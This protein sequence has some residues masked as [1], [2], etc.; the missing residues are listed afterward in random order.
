MSLSQ[1]ISSALAGVNTTQQSLSVIAGNVANTNTPG[2][3]E[4]TSSQVAQATSGQ[5]GSGVEV[6]GINRDLNTLL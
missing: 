6:A 4:E 3:V 1:A 5:P 2:Y